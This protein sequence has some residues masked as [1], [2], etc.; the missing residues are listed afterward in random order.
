[1]TVAVNGVV[2]SSYL[3]VALRLP[4]PSKYIFV[5]KN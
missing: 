3:P 1:V 5:S 2:P 4:I